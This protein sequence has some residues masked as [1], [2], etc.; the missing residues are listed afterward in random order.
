MGLFWMVSRHNLLFEK[1]ET[2]NK[3]EEYFKLGIIDELKKDKLKDLLK[4]TH[5]NTDYYTKERFS[6]SVLKRDMKTIK[7]IGDGLD[8]VIQKTSEQQIELFKGVSITSNVSWQV[9]TDKWYEQVTDLSFE[10][11]EMELIPTEIKFEKLTNLK[12]LTFKNIPNLRKLPWWIWWISLDVLEIINTGMWKFPAGTL[13]QLLRVW[14]EN[15]KLK[16]LNMTGTI[17][18]V[19][20]GASKASIDNQIEH[21]ANL[22]GVEIK[23]DAELFEKKEKERAVRIKEE[24]AKKKDD[25]FSFE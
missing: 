24:K 5:P 22:I 23:I 14:K 15:T 13:T 18:V 16:K 25:V 20:D 3:I 8:N 19:G 1:W 4:N 7:E 11:S 2:L 17:I 10:N 21:I 9:W 12:K 6:Q